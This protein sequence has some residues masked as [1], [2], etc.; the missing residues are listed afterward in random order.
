MRNFE[1]DSSEILKPQDWAFPVPIS[2]GPGRLCE[3]GKF[4]ESLKIKNPLIVTDSGSKK[5]P[6]IEKLKRF[7]NQS[8]IGSD[9]FFEIS[10]NPRDDEI[11]NGS[12]RF[13]A[14]KHDSIIT[15]GGGSAMDGGKA[16]C[17]TS[18]NDIPF[19]DFEF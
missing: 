8:N 7:L 9:L 1:I 6:F 17:L 19:W 12:S 10:P 4:F 2:Y 5:L 18:N 3:I 13:R 14:G 11:A 16:I 15:I